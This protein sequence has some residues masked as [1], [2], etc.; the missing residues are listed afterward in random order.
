MRVVH[1]AAEV[2]CGP[3][4]LALCVVPPSPARVR[5]RA[6]QRHIARADHLSLLITVLLLH[7]ERAVFL[8]FVSFCFFIFSFVKI[9][10]DSRNLGSRSLKLEKARGLFFF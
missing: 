7:H 10:E 9:F 3:L 1:R 4:R 8:F 6:V 5:V 2:R